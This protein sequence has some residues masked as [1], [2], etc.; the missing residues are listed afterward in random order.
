MDLRQLTA[1]APGNG[2]RRAI[3][4]PDGDERGLRDAI[5][6]L[7]AAGE[8]VVVDLPGHE[9][10]REELG[11]DRKLEKVSGKWQVT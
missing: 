3:L 7:R 8:V 9:G 11:C 1:L 2:K 4:A 10:A 6:G 5:A